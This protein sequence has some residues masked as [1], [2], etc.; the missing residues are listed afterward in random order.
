VRHTGKIFGIG[1]HKTG[2]SSLASALR[3]LG[4]R[5]I[6]G[7]PRGSWPGADEGIGL[8]RAIDAGNYR[9]P[10][11]E[12]FDAFVDNPYFVIW[13]QLDEM[14]QDAKLV[15]TVRDE[16]AWIDSCVRYYR[17]RR[18]RPMRLWMFGAH[19]DPSA[20]EAARQDWIEAYR[21]HNAEILDHFGSSGDRFLVMDIA[22]G[23]GWEK[24]CPFLGAPEP[25]KPFPR[26]NVGPPAQANNAELG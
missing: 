16:A 5:T 14:F 21:G 8:M 3:K 10:T 23:D 15:L 1:F 22:E 24:L 25:A 2:T 13:R 7:D 20:S 11:F 18:V 17:G 9:L 12:L 26:A 19:A 6:H 4:Y